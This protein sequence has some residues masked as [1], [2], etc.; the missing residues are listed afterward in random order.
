MIAQILKGQVL[1]YAGNLHIATLTVDG[2]AVLGCEFRAFRSPH[3][4]MAALAEEPRPLG[5]GMEETLALG[6]GSVGWRAADYWMHEGPFHR[7]CRFDEFPFYWGPF[8]GEGMRSLAAIALLCALRKRWPGLPA[9][10]TAPDETYTHL[11][12]STE[13]P[14]VEERNAML[15]RWLKTAAPVLRYTDNRS[16][17]PEWRAA[18]SAYA[19]WM[20]LRGEWTIDLHSLA[21]PAGR[22]EIWTSG[23]GISPATEESFVEPALNENT[24]IFPAGRAFFF[25]PP[26]ERDGEWR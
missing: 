5:I 18:M 9:T 21:M 17:G 2:N 15:G 24:L 23:D 7:E 10:E 26:D 11:A 22:T 25:W 4:V 13:W 20:G 16:D 19:M 8:Q 1:G 6:T 12:R 14:P 3:L